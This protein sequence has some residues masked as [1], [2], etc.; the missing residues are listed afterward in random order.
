MYAGLHRNCL[1]KTP[2]LHVFASSCHSS[3]K[4]SLDFTE[5]RNGPIV[6]VPEGPQRNG[7]I[8][9]V[10]EGPQRNG[11]IGVVPEGPPR[12]GTW[13]RLLCQDYSR[14]GNTKLQRW[15]VRRYNGDW[16]SITTIIGTST[17]HV[18]KSDSERKSLS[19]LYTASPLTTVVGSRITIQKTYIYIVNYA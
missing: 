2:R 17:H 14:C 6:V 9:V 19:S 16:Y 4:G 13:L 1:D 7:P 11:P 8:G 12:N 5:Q 3:A 15:Y 10:P 18:L